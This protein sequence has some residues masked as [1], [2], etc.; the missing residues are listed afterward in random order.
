MAEYNGLR[1]TTSGRALLAKALAGT[2]LHFTRV[3]VGDGTLPAGTEI[4]T[5]TGLVHPLRDLPIT[6]CRA[7]GAGEAEITCLLTNEGLTLGYWAREVG[8]FAQDPDVGEVLYAYTNAGELADYIPAA[9]GADLV[10]MLLTIVTVVDQ[11]AN[12]TATID[13][14]LA[15]VTH[16]ELRISLEDLFRPPSQPIEG[17]WV[18]KT[19]DGDVLRKATLPEAQRAILGGDVTAIPN[20]R[21][22]TEHLERLWASHA[23]IFDIQGQ[24]PDYDAAV[25]EAF[26]V[27]D[28]VDLTSATVTSVVSGDDSLE[29]ESLQG[30]IIG[31]NYTL[32]DGIEEEQVRLKT[33]AVAGDVRRAILE[34]PVT[35][36]YLTG[37]ARLY[38]SSVR[39]SGGLAQG[40]GTTL[41][42]GWAPGITWRGTEANA[43]TVRTLP[44][45]QANAGA[46]DISGDIA[47][48]G[49][50]ATLS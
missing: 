34:A 9:G 3:G 25:A 19:A 41:T 21:S 17:F 11:A 22:R 15:F 43:P 7:T 48:A 32:T 35:K 20:L 40:A 31:L 10:S 26:D 49:E 12:V 38:R 36:Q 5:L 18:H 37:R 28:Q 39:I 46:F 33:L 30:L 8:L 50:F 27:P 44:T 47:F 14:N 24:Y 42:Q 16:E 6:G 23:L 2:A 13:G 4:R 1:L 29:M 45:T